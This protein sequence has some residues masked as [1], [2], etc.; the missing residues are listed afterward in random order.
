MGWT[1][2]FVSHEAAGSTGDVAESVQLGHSILLFNSFANRDECAELS[3]EAFKVAAVEQSPSKVEFLTV[4]EVL[5]QAGQ[6]TSDS[7]LVQAMAHAMEQLP[8]LMPKLFGDCHMPASTC[9]FNP[10]L[11]FSEAEPW[12]IV[13]G[14]GGQFTQHTDGQALTILMP[15]TDSESCQ[16]GGTAFW[17]PKDYGAPGEN[18][19]PTFVLSPPAGS[20]I[21]FAGSVVHAGH[22]ITAGERV[23]LV[24]SFSP[25]DNTCDADT[26]WKSTIVI[27]GEKYTL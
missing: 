15:L 4:T 21:L 18:T 24:A 2:I 12:V 16:G 7:L 25:S 11:T 22:A 10:K 20:A 8:P 9:M 14:V 27:D 5:S 17:S 1:E 6:A 23:A 3:R 26:R 13:Y 19:T